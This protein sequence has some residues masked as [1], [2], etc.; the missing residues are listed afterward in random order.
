MRIMAGRRPPA[1]EVIGEYGWSPGV[2]LANCLGAA[3]FLVLAVMPRA[4]R[5]QAW[6]AAYLGSVLLVVVAAWMTTFR[7][8]TRVT[9]ESFK[10]TARRTIRWSEV[11]GV[12]R[13]RVGRRYLRVRLAGPSPGV[14]T[15]LELWGVG[16]DRAD[17]LTALVARAGRRS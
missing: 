2:A 10:L 7:P 1:G 4:Y 5:S 15:V 9:P 14:S 11:A 8:R 17:A 13:P 12:L 16:V 3:F 6:H